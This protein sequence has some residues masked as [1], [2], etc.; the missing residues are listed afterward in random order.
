MNNGFEFIKNISADDF[1]L[2]M[3]ELGTPIET[4]LVG[5]FQ[6]SGRGSK[7]DIP[8]PL[9]QDGDYSK[10][11]KDKIDY[12]GFVCIRSGGSAVTVIEDINK[13]LHYFKLKKGQA[14]IIDNKECRHAREGLVRNRILLRVW[15]KKLDIL[16]E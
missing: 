5:V 1:V 2:K 11:F 14:L 7:R 12:V 15:V 3:L 4:S 6:D 9:H 16:G 10:E 13:N 8:L